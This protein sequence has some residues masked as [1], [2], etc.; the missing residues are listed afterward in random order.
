M[1]G[2]DVAMVEL[3]EDPRLAPEPGAVLG[4]C[5]DRPRELLDHDD[6]IELA[7]PAAPDD[8]ELAPSDL[9]LDA[10]VG[11]RCARQRP[12]VRSLC[13]YLV[14]PPAGAEALAA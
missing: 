2:D 1:N 10:V 9:A 6:A 8:A 3:G 13:L 12:D 4:D 11:Q 5:G 14:L 7:M